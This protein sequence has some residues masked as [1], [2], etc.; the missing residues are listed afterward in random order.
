MKKNKLIAARNA[1]KLTQRNMADSLSVTQSQYQRREQ[2]IVNISDNEWVRL[3]KILGKEVEDIKEEDN[4]AAVNCDNPQRSPLSGNYV[5]IFESLI[6]IQ[7]DCLE[8]LKEEIK[9]LKEKVT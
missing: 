9:R 1:K 6:E 5:T 3:A 2:G 7:Q 4:M 8:L